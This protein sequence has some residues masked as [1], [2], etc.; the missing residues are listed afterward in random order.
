MTED[1]QVGALAYFAL[2]EASSRLF[3]AVDKQLRAEGGIT[4]AQ[5]E[6]LTKLNAQSDG[7]RMSDL[8]S[9][10]LVSPSGLTYQVAQLEKRGLLHRA[11]SPGDDRVVVVCITAAAQRL[12]EKLVPAHIALVRKALSGISGRADL[13]TLARLLG[14]ISKVVSV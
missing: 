3:G 9:L 8:A 10:L 4:H 5:F 12:I 11:R 6:I 13:E 2:L 7:M 14:E 1:E